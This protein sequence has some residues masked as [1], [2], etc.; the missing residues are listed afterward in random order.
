MA[1]IAQCRNALESW[2]PGCADVDED[3]RTQAHVR[4]QPELPRA[5]PRR[6]LLRPAAATATSPD[7]TTEPGPE[8]PDPAHRRQ[9][10][11]GRADRRPTSAS[12]RPGCP[13]RS[14]SRP[15]S[16]TCSSY[17]PCS[18]RLGD[19]P[20]SPAVRANGRPRLAASSG[21]AARR[22]PGRHAH[23]SQPV[24][25]GLRSPET[26][27]PPPAARATPHPSSRRTTSAPSVAGRRPG[28]A[29][30]DRP[31]GPPRRTWAAAPARPAR[32]SAGSATPVSTS[33]LGTPARLAPSMSVSSRSPTTSGSA[34][35]G[36][37][38]RLVV[39]RRLRLAGD[40]VRLA[41][42]RAR[43]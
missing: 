43:R 37:P 41:P 25:R 38:H 15:A 6:H 34:R 21:D 2:P 7:I 13:A 26:R 12:V 35:A 17:A 19:R 18:E 8:G 14:R 9:R 5:R 30:A 20:T 22:R 31:P 24:Q 39:Q 3:E 1:T 32:R 27:S 16:A 10:R 29:R 42:G 28:A 36:A 4:P 11:P 40:R 33:R 23:R